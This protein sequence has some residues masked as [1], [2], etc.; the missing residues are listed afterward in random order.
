MFFQFN[1]DFLFAGS[2]DFFLTFMLLGNFPIPYNFEKFLFITKSN[3]LLKMYILPAVPSAKIN[4]EIKSRSI[5]ILI[6]FH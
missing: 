4:I 6:T 2:F 3:I 5:F 1:L